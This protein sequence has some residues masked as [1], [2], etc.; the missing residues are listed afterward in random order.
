MKFKFDIRLFFAPIP[1]FVF[2]KVAAGLKQRREFR[3]SY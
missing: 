2:G 3:L 1:V